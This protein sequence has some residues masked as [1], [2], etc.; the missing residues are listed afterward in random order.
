MLEKELGIILESFRP[1]ALLTVFYHYFHLRIYCVTATNQT[2]HQYLYDSLPARSLS[3][4]ATCPAMGNSQSMWLLSVVVVL[5][6]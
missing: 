6:L 2:L 3:A 1:P 4:T 5:K